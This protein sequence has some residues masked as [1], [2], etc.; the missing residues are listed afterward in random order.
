MDQELAFIGMKLDREMLARLDTFA[1][2]TRRSR[3]AVIRIAIDTLTLEDLRE[4]TLD[5][6]AE[7]PVDA[8]N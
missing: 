8:Q 2:L 1:R 5:S 7:M 3:T 6:A 4:Y